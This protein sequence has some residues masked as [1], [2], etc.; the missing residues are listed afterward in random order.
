MRVLPNLI[1]AFGAAAVLAIVMPP[2]VAVQSADTA[3]AQKLAVVQVNVGNSNPSCQPYVFKLCL[4]PV[5]ERIAANLQA[6]APD[7]VTLQEVWPDARCDDV[8]DPSPHKPCGAGEEE[9]QVRRLLGADYSIACADRAGDG[10]TAWDCV[11]VR[12]EVGLLAG[13]EV[14]SHCP[15]LVE[16]VPI[17]DGCD[18]GFQTF[19]VEATLYG[20][21]VVIANAHPDSGDD[22]CRA[23]ALE[24]LFANLD[25]AGT[26]LFLGDFNL[27]P[28]NGSGASVELFNEHV[29]P[30][31]TGREYTLMSG[32]VEH[33]P[34]Y[35]TF[36]LTDSSQLDPTGELTTPIVIEDGGVSSVIDH[37]AV[38]GGSGTCTTL[39]EAPGTERLDGGGGM[40]HRALQCLVSLGAGVGPAAPVADAT[41]ENDD[42]LPV[43]GGGALGGLG[44]LLTAALLGR[45]P[46][47]PRA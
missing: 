31:G 9:P 24:Q 32:I 19:A 12:T 46:A 36:R 20:A 21:P 40:D 25:G 6:L 38:R 5:A 30:P 7:V 39:G 10:T 29:G 1:V 2:A 45:L 47:A 44:L 33:D 37:A 14:G 22:A 42:P 3:S 15:A 8:A 41:D 18:P 23:A 27:D 17:P 13:C 16:P 11:A 28:Y 43:T 34:P 26:T 35:P 4:D